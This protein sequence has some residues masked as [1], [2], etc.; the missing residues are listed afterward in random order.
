MSMRYLIRRSKSADLEEIR[1]EISNLDSH[2]E[3]PAE[4]L[5][6]AVNIDVSSVRSIHYQFMTRKVGNDWQWI[7]PSIELVAENENGILAL[8]KRFGLPNPGHLGV[9][10][11]DCLE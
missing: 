9:Y 4:N 5:R 11:T 7:C 3:K 10:S 1:K 6:R 2:L 8:T